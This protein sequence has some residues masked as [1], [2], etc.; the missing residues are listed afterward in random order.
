MFPILTDL[1][2]A[3]PA[4]AVKAL[5]W[6]FVAGFAERLVPGFLENFADSASRKGADETAKSQAAPTETSRAQAHDE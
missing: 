2:P 1:Y 3:L 4:I 5:F 6:S